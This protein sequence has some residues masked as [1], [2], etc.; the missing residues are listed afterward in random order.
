MSVR[1]G[2]LD[3]TR[4]P[5]HAGR[6]LARRA[7][8]GAGAPGQPVDAAGAGAGR[9]RGPRGRLLHVLRR[10]RATCRPARS[11]AWCTPT[12][13][14]C[15]RWMLTVN[16]G[17]A[18]AAALG[19]PSSTTRPRSSSPTRTCPACRPTRSGSAGCAWSATAC[20]SGSRCG[21]SPASRC[22]I[23][24]RLAVG[25][26]FADLFEIKDVVRDRSARSSATHAPDGV[27][28]QF[29]YRNGELHGRRPGSRRRRRPTRSTATTWSGSS[30]SA[31]DATWAV[32]LT[33]PLRDRSERG[34]CRSAA[35]SAR[36]ADG[37]RRR[38]DRA[39]VRRDARR[40]TT[41]SDLLRHIGEQT[42]G[43]CWRCGWR[44]E[45]RRANGSSCP[46]PACRGF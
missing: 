22:A 14:C 34:A 26:D 15:R 6:S 11:A 27:G 42:A 10:G 21:A 2:N 19:Q 1:V 45:H 16:G 7:G 28:L 39:L 25:N 20:A 41:D 33:V 3:W 38:R 36:S 29:G 5:A 4:A 17:A 40:C 35:A 46:R 43:T 9:G 8:R 24:L 13:G 12:P 30:T 23:E 18:A 37:T 32:E 44:R 31:T